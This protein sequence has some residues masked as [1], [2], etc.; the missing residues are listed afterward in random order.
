VSGTGSLLLAGP[1]IDRGYALAPDDGG[2]RSRASAS[3]GA[4]AA[5]AMRHT[6]SSLAAG[7][8]KGFAVSKTTYTRFP[9]A[10]K[11]ATPLQRVFDS[12]R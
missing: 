1:I 9:S 8:S 10:S 4:R 6:S 5:D 2:A 3:T 7:A 12:P 11:T